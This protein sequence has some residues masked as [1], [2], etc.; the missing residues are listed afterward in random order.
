MDEENTGSRAVAAD[1]SNPGPAPQSASRE[2]VV[3]GKTCVVSAD[4]LSHSQLVQLAFGTLPAP[5]RGENALTVSYRGGPHQAPDGIL[6]PHERVQ[7][8]DGETF[9]VTRTNAS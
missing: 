4:N 1:L 5:G 3:N 6:A 8:A 2:I 9:N 7:I